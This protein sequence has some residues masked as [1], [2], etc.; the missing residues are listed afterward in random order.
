MRPNHGG[1]MHEASWCALLHWRRFMMWLRRGPVMP[2]LPKHL[3][4]QRGRFWD[5]IFRFTLAGGFPLSL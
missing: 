2:P 1:D 5:F 3:R 4:M